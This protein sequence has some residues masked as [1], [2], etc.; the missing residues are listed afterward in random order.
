MITTRKAGQAEKPD[1]LTGWE[2]AMALCVL[3][4]Y[5]ALIILTIETLPYVANVAT[6]VLFY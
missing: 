4:L 5:V 3:L 1:S 6:R 2:K